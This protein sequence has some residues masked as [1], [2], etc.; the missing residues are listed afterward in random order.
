MKMRM[1]QALAVAA[2]SG[3]LAGVSAASVNRSLWTDPI[4]DT[5]VRRTDSGADGVLLSGATLPDVVSV[6]FIPWQPICPVEDPY[7]GLP[8]TPEQANMVRIDVVF[9]GLVNPPGPLGLNGADYAPDRFGGSPAYGFFEI[10]IDRDR[11]TG[12][13]FPGQARSRILATAGRFGGRVADPALSG[14]TAT[15]AA[16]I[17]QFWTTAPFIERT[18]TDFALALCGC[19]DATIVSETGNM[20]GRLDS[21]ECMI[22]SGRFFQRAGGYRLASQIVGGSDIGLYDPVVNLRFQH[23]PSSNLTVMTLVFP[24]NPA[25]AAA[26]T[27]EPE[28]PIDTLIGDGSHFSLQ[29][30]I[31]DLVAGAASGASGLTYEL[32]HRWVKKDPA[33]CLNPLT[34][35]VACTVATAYA[36]PEDSLYVWTDAGFQTLTGDV[37][38]DGMLGVTD[39]ASV[40]SFI[41]QFDGTPMDMDGVTDGSLLLEN[42]GPNFSLFD[43][44]GDGSVGQSD[45]NWFHFP[46]SCPADWDRNGALE[47]P[48]IFAFLS[49]W[50]AGLGD[51]DG[52]GVNEVPDIF[53]FLAEWFA[54]NCI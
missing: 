43:I 19:F 21:G 48:D 6:S 29:E 26:L 45:V 25:G 37:T 34:W 50:F 22:V 2:A 7:T 14:R 20:D 24:L 4:G 47:V 52:N 35:D 17:D 46:N 41:A 31:A 18:G 16:D 36:A 42:I 13:E 15:C 38:G 9:A 30:A 53:A 27:G 8:A 54:N 44:T 11:D 49:S 23:E 10:D 1:K 28:Q 12:G 51:F 39:Q 33:T 5:V 32:I 3:V 40:E